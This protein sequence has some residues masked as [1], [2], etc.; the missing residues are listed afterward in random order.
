ML[1]SSDIWFYNTFGA[2]FFRGQ[3]DT[4]IPTMQSNPSNSC[5][6]NAQIY[7]A[8]HLSLWTNAT[9]V[10]FP[11]VQVVISTGYPMERSTTGSL[12]VSNIK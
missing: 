5:F 12:V 6:M 9:S 1:S 4:L 7:C 2:S 8:Y 11:G 10:A 3:S